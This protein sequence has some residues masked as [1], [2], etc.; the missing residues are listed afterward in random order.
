MENLFNCID[1]AAWAF[2]HADDDILA[3]SDER[4]FA[5]RAICAAFLSRNGTKYE[6]GGVGK[7][8]LEG[9]SFEQGKWLPDYI[10]WTF[11]EKLARPYTPNHVVLALSYAS[12]SVNELWEW[13]EFARREAQFNRHEL[14]T[15]HQEYVNAKIPVRFYEILSRQPGADPRCLEILK[16]HL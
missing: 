5:A 14:G 8:W 7:Y 3:D 12:D 9:Q 11:Y 4:D 16:A 2:S 1:F 10:R 13:K 15:H 6:V